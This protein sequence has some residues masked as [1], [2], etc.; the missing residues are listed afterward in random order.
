MKELRKD[1]PKE[2]VAIAGTD[3]W[4]GVNHGLGPNTGRRYAIHK[5]DSRS[6]WVEYASVLV[7]ADFNSRTGGQV[8]LVVVRWV[9]ELT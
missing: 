6:C 8:P 7:V 5:Y 9:M 2:T 4:V 1:L 3:D